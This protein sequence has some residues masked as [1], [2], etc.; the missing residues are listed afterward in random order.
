M[1][2]TQIS[3][4]DLTTSKVATHKV[5]GG[6]TKT[7]TQTKLQTVVTL[8]RRKKGATIDELTK[9]TGW[10]PHSVRSLISGTIKKKMYFNVVAGK[11]QNSQMRYRIAT[12]KGAK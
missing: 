12:G 6:K 9:A 8:L 10:Q 1:Q 7:K 3:T 11:D 4:P 2:N 5:T